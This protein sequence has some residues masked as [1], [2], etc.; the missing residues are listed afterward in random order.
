MSKPDEIIR[1]NPIGVIRSPFPSPL[2]TPIQPVFDTKQ[3]HATIDI[4]PEFQEGLAD[5]EEF[6]RIWLIYWCDR[7]KE[8]GQ[9]RIKPFLDDFEHGVFATRS[10][11]RPNPIGISTVELLGIEATKIHI[12]G[13]DIVDGTPLLDIKPYVSAFDAFPV[14]RCG[15]F[16]RC[17]GKIKTDDGRFV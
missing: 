2:G 17:K 12:R 13:V 8:R 6:E 14:Q 11:S 9:L 5:L 15:W 10:P 4:L 3:T 1:F 7:I 16:D